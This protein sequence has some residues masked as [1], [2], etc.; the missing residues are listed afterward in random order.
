MLPRFSPRLF[1]STDPQ[2]SLSE[3]FESNFF[4][5]TNRVFR[6]TAAFYHFVVVCD[7]TNGTAADRGRFYVN[8]VRETDYQLNTYE[9]I[10]QEGGAGG[11]QL[12][13]EAGETTS[14][15]MG[16]FYRTIRLFTEA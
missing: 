16:M 4:L 3:N 12:T 6:D 11:Q 10:C 7:A 15:L 14:H 9:N 8:G 1:P 2:S 5:A 13:N